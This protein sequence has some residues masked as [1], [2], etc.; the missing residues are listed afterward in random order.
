MRVRL[1][2][3]LAA[4]VAASCTPAQL[5][6]FN[7]QQRERGA[8]EF[9]QTEAKD[10]WCKNTAQN[11]IAWLG[12]D[13]FFEIADADRTLPDCPVTVVSSV[14]SWPWDSL[15]Q[16]ESGGNWFINTG[17]G[18]YGGLQFSLISWRSAGGPYGYPHQQ[19]R[20][21]QIRVGQELQRMQGWG[22][23]PSCSRQLGLR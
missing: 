9:T 21:V 20:E 22:A 17:N 19:S 2:L 15:A 8:P 18:F 16:C 11:R 13:G 10:A 6:V 4:L 7:A 1:I 3:L 14:S 5:S 12:W 23:W